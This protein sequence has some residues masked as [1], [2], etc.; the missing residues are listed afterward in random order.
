[1]RLY[2][3]AVIATAV[4]ALIAAA[5]ARP[6]LDHDW[7]WTM[8]ILAAL[9]TAGELYPVHVGL[10][11]KFTPSHVATFAGALTLGPFLAMLLAATSK[12]VGQRLSRPRTARSW[13]NLAFNAANAALSTGAGAAVYGSLTVGT[14]EPRAEPGA[15][16][17]AAI[18]TYA[19]NQG[20]VDVV[21]ALQLRRS[22]LLSWWSVHRRDFAEQLTLYVF[23][24]IAA[25]ASM[26]SPFALALFAAPMV[27]FQVATAR[28]ARLHEET[29]EVIR[30]LADIVDL[31][32]PYTHG[33]SQRV[34]ALAE[35]LARRLKMQPAQ[36]ELVREAAR[37][38]DIGKI[39][40]DDHLLRK[41]GPLTSDEVVAMHRHADIGHRIVSRIGDL[42]DA[43][44]LVRSHHE[45]YDG[46]GYPRGLGGNELP[47]EV[48]VL[49]VADAFDAMTSDRPYRSAMPREA[50]RAELLAGR[51]I[52][53]NPAVVDA[54]VA[55][56]DE[57]QRV[58][59]AAETRAAGARLGGV[60][61]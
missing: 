18:T 47:W 13:Y 29:L 24:A 52:Q 28:T 51:G 34:A 48:G 7:L 37:L 33:H 56:I 30:H 36:V 19:I 3:G 10:K 16:A 25:I 20:L 22:P 27:L 1:M 40:T 17:A 53:W 5:G 32:D 31:R 38:H 61:A 46:R 23:G 6:R 15:I 42:A 41:P 26:W 49:A 58:A 55:L 59:V 45:R 2:V 12:S 8:A 54:F 60:V 43:A 50:A 11:V 4:V 44:E 9:A 35:R 39:G 21:V 57:D 14:A